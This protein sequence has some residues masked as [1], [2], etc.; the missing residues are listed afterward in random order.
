M[1]S[2]PSVDRASYFFAHT[3]SIEA[4][5][6]GPWRIKDCVMSSQLLLQTSSNTYERHG[7]FVA[8][9][10]HELRFELSVEK[11]DNLRVIT[12]FVKAPRSP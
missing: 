6:A 7:Y 4:S 3:K 9:R 10:A 12:Q 1:I 5:S 11:F 8:G 2:I